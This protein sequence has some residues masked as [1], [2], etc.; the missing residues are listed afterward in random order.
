MVVTIVHRSAEPFFW[1]GEKRL[2]C[3]LVHGFT[4]SPGDMRILGEHLRDKGYGVSGILLPGHGTSPRELNK[5]GWQ[6]WYGA[7]EA[8]Y[9]RIKKEYG[10]VP[11]VPMG[12]SMGGT[13]VLRLACRHQAEG[14]VAFSAPVFLADSRAYEP[15]KSGMEYY[16]KNKTPQELARDE[17]EGRFS[18]GVIPMKAFS[19]LMLLIEAIKEELALISAPALLF[20]SRA[21]AA[22]KPESASFLYEHIGSKKKKLVWLEKSGHVVT[23]GSE[24]AL[25]FQAVR[26]FLEEIGF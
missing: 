17:A 10:G 12:L 14:V 23:L 4:G 26:E 8:E 18:Y 21:D 2:F 15:V 16:P 6:E 9:L 7:V 20:Q 25:V 19:S 3:L 24:R 13:L 5:T 11:V 1:E 22:V